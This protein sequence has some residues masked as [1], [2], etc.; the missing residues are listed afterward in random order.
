MLLVAFIVARPILER[1]D[2]LEK[3]ISQAD[4]LVA[5]HESLLAARP[6]HVAVPLQKPARLLRRQILRRVRS[7][8]AAGRGGRMSHAPF[9]KYP[10]PALGRHRQ[11]LG[12]RAGR[13][14]H[15]PGDAARLLLLAF[16]YTVLYF[17]FLAN[18]LQ[19]ERLAERVE[20]LN[21]KLHIR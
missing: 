17:C 21:A 6:S 16:T 15:D 13:L 7:E 8:R 20:Q 12:H 1:R 3:E 11:R 10:A 4:R 9:R 14:R 5:E 2:V 19:L 18:R